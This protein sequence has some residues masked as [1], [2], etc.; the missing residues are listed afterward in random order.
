MLVV[1]LL[2]VIVSFALNLSIYSSDVQHV[3]ERE[4]SGLF[5]QRESLQVLSYSEPPE[6]EWNKTYGG[7]ESD[8]ASCVVQTSD[9]GY[10]V[11]G[12]T[13]F[14]GDTNVWLVK[15]DSSGNAEWDKKFGEEDANCQGHSLVQTS[16]GGYAIGGRHFTDLR[17]GDFWLI[18]TDLYGNMEWNKTYGG[19]D[20][21]G[22]A[23][24]VQ[25]GDGG[26]VLA[27]NTESYGSGGPD[28]WLV[29]TNSSGEIEWTRTY[30]GTDWDSAVS[31]V[32]TNDGGYAVAG[33]TS[34]F[35]AWSSDFW[36]V[37]T[38]VYGNMEWNKTYGG[39]DDEG[40]GFVVQTS[41]G[42]YAVAGST[43]SFGSG[44][45][46]F[47]LVKTDS[48]GNA[49]WNRTYGGTS[50]DEVE[51]LVQTSDGGYIMAGTTIS[52]GTGEFDV[53]LVRTDSL[54]N[55]QWNRTYGGTDFDF[56]RSIKQTS[57]GGYVVAGRTDSFGSGGGDFW[58]IKLVPEEVGV[59][60]W[61]MF[62]HDPRHA[63]YST[64]E[65]PNTNNVLWT[66]TTGG[67]VWSSPT[68]VD[69]RVY[70]GSD[71]HNVY[72]L[73]ALTGA[74]IWN[75]TTGNYVWSSPAVVNGN[76]YVGQS[77]DY[78]VYCL[79]AA[80][81]A[82]IWNYTTGGE[83]RSCPV[84]VDGRVYIG[85][86]DFKVYCLNA[87]N[88]DFIWSYT[89][90]GIIYSSPAVADG[91]VYVGSY[92]DHMV[93][94]L[95]ATNGA[96][97]W[98]Y[99]TGDLVY[100]SPAV[101]DGRVYIGSWDK[102]VYCLNATNGD[103]IWSY[104]TGGAVVSCPAV[105]NGKVYVG[106]S[107]D[108][109]VYCLNATSGEHIWSYTT[110]GGVFSSPAVADGK[111]YVGSFDNEFYC[112]N[113]TNGEKIW[114]Y[115][116]GGAN[117]CPAIADGKVYVG[118]AYGKV[119]CFGLPFGVHD[120][121]IINVTP[122]KTVVGQNYS[123]SINVTVENQ[124]TFTENFNVTTYYNLT[125]HDDFESGQKPQW[126]Y[127]AEN[128]DDSAVV[129]I[130][131]D[132]YKETPTHSLYIRNLYGNYWGQNNG[133]AQAK[134][135]ITE[136]SLTIPYTIEFWFY[137]NQSTYYPHYNHWLILGS[138]QDINLMLYDDPN[139]IR[140]YDDSGN[141]FLSYPSFMFQS[142]HKIKYT[143]TD[144]NNYVLKIDN[145][146]WTGDP[147]GDSLNDTS[148]ILPFGDYRSEFGKGEGY[149]DD[150]LIYSGIIETKTVTNLPPGE[151]KTLTFAWNT[152][153]FTL[154]NYA[155]SAYATPVPYETDTAD[156]TFTD[157]SV[158]VTIPGDITG[159]FKC[160]GKDVAL[161]SKYYNKPAHDCPSADI[162]NDNKIDGKDVA[163]ISKYYDTH[164][165]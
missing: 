30:G 47:W 97:V 78:E 76:V 122:S 53:W 159:D 9:G 33:W 50:P 125:F 56:G 77:Y 96:Y 55:A 152:T 23:F 46:D 84:V 98:S 124:G 15:T 7:T 73:N 143:R 91:K 83:V 4:N 36:L 114:N 49:Q 20:D 117:S 16:D 102:K 113:A 64:S 147:Y 8:D 32:Q 160:E 10:A 17:Q 80:T 29:K 135:N 43:Q 62:R 108:H 153:G 141:Q 106:G 86:G 95:N 109:K 70:I 104:T 54:G 139:G 133:I 27:G 14:G 13:I 149:W 19:F 161:I 41:D 12:W 110:G 60:W 59:D 148:T 107:S 103:F 134:L 144:A 120:I 151:E 82:K 105:A 72:C 38:D 61:P 88:G 51:S 40:P 121:A 129:E 1:V 25:T 99:T 92:D 44:G 136:L 6:T 37:K 157:G 48:S 138:D 155:I 22:P 66:Y 74:K 71:D 154:G 118:S 65:V 132:L 115:T 67:F 140:L 69:S 31:V 52:F 2:F 162:N 42:G 127:Y 5:S 100:S 58:L 18:K 142:W 116:T 112:L 119:Y 79:N 123:M 63:G 145:Y 24:V 34:L 156:N 75:Y 57:D 111:V 130:N 81:G 163:V 137:P 35:P 94:C 68:V 150:I 11:V 21:E 45:G 128:P 26:Y 164:Y 85:S 146:T 39:F 93:Y 87:T 90:G 3:E 158:I 126:T 165:P 131:Q 101:V 28:F 89:T